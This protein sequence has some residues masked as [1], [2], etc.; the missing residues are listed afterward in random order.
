MSDNAQKTPLTKTLN[1]FAYKKVLDQIQI[2]GKSLPCSVVS[3]QGSIITV[4]FEVQSGFTLP[5]VTIPM[6]GPEYV[7]YPI[8][9]GDQGM[10]IAAD[11]RLGGVSGLGGGV[12]DLSTP[13]NLT[14]LVFLPISN[15]AWSAVDEDSVTIYGPNGVVLR[16][17]G[18]NS[19]VTLTPAGVI[20]TARDVFTIS[21]GPTVMS[22]NAAGNFSL[23]G[24][25]LTFTDQFATTSPETMHDVWDL[26]V[27]W[28][29]THTHTSSGSGI[30]T[31]PFA[32]GSIAP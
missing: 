17:T 28:L 7:R 16:D 27:T 25:T 2:L 20:I 12:A 15:V 4:K 32:G 26:L 8:Q 18:S 6:F 3:K 29:N 14:A 5:L 31:T 21:C 1:E 11:A 30:P 10:V 19:V 24:K 23:T 22:M 13:A 9:P